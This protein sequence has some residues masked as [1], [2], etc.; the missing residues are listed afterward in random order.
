MSVIFSNSKLQSKTIILFGRTDVVHS[1]LNRHLSGEHSGVFGLRKTGKT[2]ILYGVDRALKRENGISIWIDFQHHHFKRW[3]RLLFAIIS[4]IISENNIDLVRSESDYCEEKAPTLFESDMLYCYKSTGKLLIFFDEIEHIT[5]NISISDH[6]K[7]GRDYIKFWQVI[8]S[9]SQKH[10][11][12][13]TYI[14]AG[15]NPKCIE[16]TRVAGVDNPIY[17][18]FDPES[19]IK[20]FDTKSTK[21]MVNKL[22][23][24]MGLEFDDIVCAALTQDYGG[25]PFLIRHVCK[26]INQLIKENQTL[27]KPLR[28]NKTIYDQGKK[29]F[30]EKYAER[31]YEMIIEVLK[32]FYYDEYQVLVYLALGDMDN[33]GR[34]AMKSNNLY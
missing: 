31:Y 7:E 1:L 23:G 4:T 6:W 10:P 24:Y 17:S 20:A 22:G 15:T 2:S 13:F 8:R 28:V 14:I 33:F 11:D 18:Q 9:C 16:T 27:N 5:F 12:L 3:N 32:E 34:Y 21:E 19:Y 25:H 29:L 26:T 30:E